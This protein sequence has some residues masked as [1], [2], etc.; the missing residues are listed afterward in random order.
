MTGKPSNKW[1]SKVLVW[2]LEL[3]DWDS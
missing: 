3:P 1:D 2:D